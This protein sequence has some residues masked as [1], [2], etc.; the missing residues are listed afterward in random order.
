MFPIAPPVTRILNH[1]GMSRVPNQAKEI[2]KLRMY[3]DIIRMLFYTVST[4]VQQMC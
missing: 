2:S 1:P 4:C 3:F